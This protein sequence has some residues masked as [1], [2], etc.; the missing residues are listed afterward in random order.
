[1][2]LDDLDDE[3]V[4]TSGESRK[5]AD[6]TPAQF[7]KLAAREVPCGFF[8]LTLT[9]GS[10]KRFRIRLERGNFLTGQRTLSR[11]CKIDSGDDAEREW[12]TIAVVGPSGFAVFKRWRGEWEERWAIALW[13]VLHGD[14]T[15]GYSVEVEPRCWMTMRELKTPAAKE[16]GLCVTWL[17]KL[18]I[19]E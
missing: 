12:E 13:R 18:K 17:K 11:Y 4:R 1:M 6:I 2:P 15:T 10:V 7:A 19:T 3:P 14:T 5:R 16:A 9:D 8:S